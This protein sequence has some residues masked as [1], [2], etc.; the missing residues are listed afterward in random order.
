MIVLPHNILYEMCFGHADQ[1][2]ASR[3]SSAPNL[4]FRQTL[5]LPIR[6]FSAKCCPEARNH[7]H[8]HIIVSAGTVDINTSTRYVL[9]CDRCYTSVMELFL[10]L[11]ILSFQ[12]TWMSPTPITCNCSVLDT[13][14]QLLQALAPAEQDPPRLVQKVPGQLFDR[15]CRKP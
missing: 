9:G 11:Q 2:Q 5:L 3:F 14:C 8:M 10:I 12:S 1:S 13:Q 15:H 4:F 7:T 6:I